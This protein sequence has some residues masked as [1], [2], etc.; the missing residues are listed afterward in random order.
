MSLFRTPL[1]YCVYDHPSDYPDKWV[2]RAFVGDVPTIIL[3]EA[4]TLDQLR[5]LKP[6]RMNIIPRMTNDDPCIAECWV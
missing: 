5:E 3:F 2:A 6:R 4:D 1:L